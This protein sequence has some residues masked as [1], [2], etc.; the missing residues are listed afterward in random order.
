[1]TGRPFLAW[2]GS[3]ALTLTALAEPLSKRTEIDFFRDV[4]SRNLKGLATRSDGR[5]VPGPSFTDLA[6]PA[7]AD[8]LWAIEPG[9]SAGT[10]L[11]GTGPE[12]RVVEAT[13]AADGRSFTSREL[14]RLDEAQVLALHR[15]PDGAIL[16]G[17]SPKGGLY[18]LREGKVVARTGLPV[19][20]LLD[21]LR[22]DDTTVLVATGNPG[23]IY[24][25]DLALF[26]GSGVS[27]EKTT[28]ASQLAARGLTVFGEV[29][30][31]NVRRIVALADGRIAAGSAPRGNVYVFPRP[32][33][34]TP[35]QPVLLQE[36]R[37]AEVT[38]LLPQPNGD[39]YAS[40]VFSPTGTE[41][42]VAPAGATPKPPA[43]DE[44]PP[45]AQVERFGGRS[46]V[47]FFPAA[48]FPE[49]LVSRS[50]TAIYRLAR[51]GDVLLA[52]GG[53]L[54]ELIGYDLIARLSLT[55][56]GSASSQLNGLLPVPG[57][58][59]RFLLLRN[60]SPGLAIADFRG[61][62][63][64]EAETRRLELPVPSRLGALRFGRLRGVADADLRLE[65]RT[66]LGSDE[67][68]G[69]GPWTPLAADADGGWRGNDLRGRHVRLRLRL[70]AAAAEGPAGPRSGLEL[71]RATL[72]TLPQNRRPQLQEFRLLP[73]GYSIIPGVEPAPSANSTLGAVLDGSKDGDR[74]RSTLLGSQVVPSPGN[75]AVVWNVTDPD[76]DTLAY[77][78]AVRAEGESAWT[79]LAVSIRESVVQFDTSHWSEGRYT[80]R[81]VAAESA[82]R[83]AA[84][85]LSHTFET[86]ELVVDHTPPEILRAEAV[87]GSAAV[88]ITL[89]ARD[90]LSLL[91][92]IEVVFNNGVRETL[93]QPA[94][95]IRDGREETFVLEIPLARVPTATSAEVTVYDRA[96]NGA[97]RRVRW[98]G[99]TP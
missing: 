46:A 33:G 72:F 85:R 29:R 92:G 35:A 48:G 56:A 45:P 52:A 8:L 73:P 58:P 47:V 22:L 39:L 49:T 55:F 61:A 21:F 68:E 54:G 93:E 36:N 5:L 17:T 27:P 1:M 95:G 10:F 40:L 80:T 51:H 82:P 16:A 15:L 25:L 31:R 26:A 3:L 14:V 83:P 66:S 13:L 24:R 65:L 60:N 4:P 75:Q 18:L 91:E 79:D 94:D 32:G 9:G 96:G 37:D 11:I 74:R 90:R 62:G 2:A 76:G 41:A 81:L 12:G 57:S 97:T 99:T 19:D 64:R 6:G 38:D 23:R 77:S 67:V 20:S 50:S 42:R 34:A 43:K 70:P 87:R 89:Q 7:P 98:A 59:D 78:F 30:D 63:V 88:V 69:W 28:E 44:T 53:E 86:D 84:E 71:D